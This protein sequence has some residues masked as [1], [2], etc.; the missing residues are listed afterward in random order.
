M[1]IDEIC[2]MGEWIKSITADD[3]ILLLWS[4]H[5][6]KIDDLEPSMPA[7]VIEAWGFK[8]STAVPWVKARYDVRKGRFVYQV[9]GGHTVRS[10]SEEMLIGLKGVVSRIRLNQGIPGAIIAPRPRPEHSAKPDDQYWIAQALVGDAPKL[11]IFARQ[12]IPGWHCWG[13][14]VDCSAWQ[15]VTKYENGIYKGESLKGAVV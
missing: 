8:Y 3:A 15:N 9:S 7:R 13:N 12:L 6:I 5:P 10:C 14:Q 2:A 11:E 4:T 1:G